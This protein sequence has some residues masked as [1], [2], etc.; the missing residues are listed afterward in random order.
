MSYE[1][2]VEVIP[3]NADEDR[4]VTALEGRDPQIAPKVALRALSRIGSRTGLKAI[5]RVLVDRQAP[6]EMRVG[7]ART[8]GRSR[9]GP[10]QDAL[11]PLL[12]DGDPAVVAAAADSL[13]RIGNVQALAALEAITPIADDAHSR[14]IRFAQSLLSYRLGVGSHL[15]Q[16]PPESAFVVAG[17]DAKPVDQRRAPHDIARRA[18]ED[19][20]RDLPALPLIGDGAQLLQCWGLDLLLAPTELVATSEDVRALD[21][22]NAIPAMLLRRWDCPERWAPSVLLLTH[23]GRDG[24]ELVATRVDGTIIGGGNATQRDAHRDFN[25]RSTR[26][27]LFPAV[28]VEGSFSTD[29]GFQLDRAVSAG[30]TERQGRMRTPRRAG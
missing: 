27:G 29:D 10:G 3:S 28:E 5:A 8:L 1:A 21:D 4:L 16:S 19:A 24:A 18:I 13:G 2:D 6:T 11:L 15:V 12:S 30:K 20:A 7:A 9:G 14:R 23:P 26:S 17:S 25:L 22:R